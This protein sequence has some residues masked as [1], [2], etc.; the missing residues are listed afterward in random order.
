MILLDK[1]GEAIEMG[2]TYEKYQN[3]FYQSFYC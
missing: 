3:I 2:I 1:Y